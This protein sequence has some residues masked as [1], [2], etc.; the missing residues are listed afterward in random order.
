MKKPYNHENPDKELED[1]PGANLYTMSYDEVEK[2]LDYVDKGHRL[3]EYIYDHTE[4]IGSTM[5]VG[6]WLH[7]Y[8]NA[9]KEYDM[10]V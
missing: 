5:N 4:I 6:D 1:M 7:T 9:I 8:A 3:R 10:D 2:V